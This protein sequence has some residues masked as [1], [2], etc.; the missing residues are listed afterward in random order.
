MT[1]PQ[2]EK[3]KTSLKT[4]PKPKQ[5]AIKME[6]EFTN[7]DATKTQ[8]GLAEIKKNYDQRTGRFKAI[9]FLDE[10]QAK[11]EAFGTAWQG[12]YSRGHGKLAHKAVA[13]FRSVEMVAG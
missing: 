12:H 1:P 6:K 7:Y 10:C 3:T 5:T 11:V 4:P 2:P 13:L 8:E 9:G